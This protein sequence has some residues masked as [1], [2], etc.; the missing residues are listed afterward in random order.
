MKNAEIFLDRIMLHNQKI[1]TLNLIENL[2]KL[3][4]DG[5]RYS[6]I[7]VQEWWTR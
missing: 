5:K 3:N 1:S 4:L 2:S 7:T 6:Q